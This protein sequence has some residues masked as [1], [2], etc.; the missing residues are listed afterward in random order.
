MDW[1]HVYVKIQLCQVSLLLAHTLNTLVCF[2]V[3]FHILIMYVF[4]I[5]NLFFTLKGL[6]KDEPICTFQT[7][8]GV[9]QVEFSSCGTKLY[10]AVRKNSEFLCW[11]LRN[12]G[13][14]LYCLEGR[15]C[16]T[17]Q[18]I[19]FSVTTDNKHMISGKFGTRS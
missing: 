19:K 1:F 4:T 9:T 14:V 13:T 18:R 15:Q 3:I 12:P 5:I 6:Y 8:S 11:D 16:D 10:S 2:Y 7:S 17:N